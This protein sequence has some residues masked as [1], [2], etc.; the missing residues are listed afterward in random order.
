M[1]S[2]TVQY[3]DATAQTAAQAGLT[4]VLRGL[5]F[6]AIAVVLTYLFQGWRAG[7]LAIGLTLN[8]VL[9]VAMFRMTFGDRLSLVDPGMIFVFVV[10]LYTFVPLI[11]FEAFQFNFGAAADSRL[12][13]IALDDDIISRVVTDANMVIAGFGSAYLIFRKAQMPQ[14]PDVLEGSAV[15]AFWV[16]LVVALVARVALGAGT[17]DI[18]TDEYLVVQALP[19]FAIQL[20]NIVSD[21]LYVGL[22]GLLVHYVLA[23]RYVLAG[24]IVAGCL[25]LILVAT[26]AR[27][28]LAMILFALIVVL[29]HIRKRLSVG[30]IATVIGLLLAVFTVLGAIRGDNDSLVSVVAQSEFLSVFT[31][32]L[33]IHQIFLAGSALDMN[34]ALLLSDLLRLVP[35]QLITVQKID[36]ASWYVSTFYPIYGSSGGGLA[37]GMLAESELSGGA[38]SALA[39]GLALGSAICLALN[40]LTRGRSVWRYIIYLWLTISIYQCFRDTTFTLAGR[41]VFQFGPAMLLCL[42]LTTMLRREPHAARPDLPTYSGGS[43]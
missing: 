11:S 38:L 26:S 8:L 29:D 13:N 1:N 14:R 24:T 40:V 32:A 12:Y 41:F 30:V 17:G 5:G 35:Q 6:L 3:L 21:G 22:F 33:D 28:P 18:Y 4:R 37:F 9:F 7:V 23:R 39:R 2:K 27:T 20:L 34:T 15:T 16:V 31:T 10:F 42:L 19:L 43:N 36:P 25:A